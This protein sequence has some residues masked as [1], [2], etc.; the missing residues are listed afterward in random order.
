MTLVDARQHEVAFCSE[1]SK[2]SDAIFQG[3]PDLPFHSS[4]IEQYGQGSNK[5]QDFRVYARVGDQRGQLAL[6]GEVKLPGTPQGSSPFNAILLKDAHD[7]A[8]NIACRYYFTWNVERLALF[9]R[10][11]WNRPMHEQCIGQWDLGLVVNSHS[12]L[13]LPTVT[14]KIQE[15]LL[16][17]FYRDFAEIWSGRRDN[18]ATAPDEFYIS[19]LD[20]HLRGP[21]GPVRIM[22]DYLDLESSRNRTFDIQLRT[23][24]TRIQ[25]WN[26]DRDDPDSWRKAI[27]RAAASV[28]YVLN[29]RILFYEAVRARYGELR[30]LRFP[31][32]TKTAGEAVKFLSRQFQ[33]AIRVTGDYDTVLMPDQHEWAAE[34]ALSGTN[35]IQSWQQVIDGVERFNF[36]QIPSDILGRTFQRLVSPEERHKFGQHYTDET[37]VDVINAFC[38]R[39]GADDVLDPACG[40]GS[41]LVRAYYRKAYLDRSLASHE[42]VA[43]LYGCDINPFPAHLATLNLAARDL[44][45]G[46]YPR[47]A[48]RNFFTVEPGK[49]FCEVPKETRDKRGNREHWRV[50]LPELDAVVGNP[51][52]VRQEQ[53][54]KKDEP[55]VI[56][57]QGKEF[58]AARAQRAFPGIGLS[59]QSDLHVYFW[60]VAADLLK[61]GGWF[62]FLTSS[63]W[64]DVRYGFRLQRWILTNFRLVAIIESLDEPWFQDA[65]V[66]TAVTILQRTADPKKR[67]GNLVRFV[68]LLRPLSV[69]LGAR[70]DEE[71]KQRG[72]ERLRNLIV[73]TKTDYADS[74]LRIVV[75]RQRDLWEE[76]VAVGPV[77]ARSGPAGRSSEAEDSDNEPAGTQQTNGLADYAGGKWGRYLRAPEFYFRV[78]RRFGPRFTRFGEVADIRRG[79]TSGCDAFFMPRDVTAATLC[80][81]PNDLKWRTLPAVTFGKRSDVAAGKVAVVR[82]GDGTLHCVER[83]YLKLEAHSLMDVG[84]PVVRA[85]DLDR[86]VLWVNQSMK[87]LEGQLIHKFLRWGA[88][89]T[90]ASARSKAIPLPQRSTC[91]GREMWYDLTGLTPGA[92]FWPM[93]Q[94]YRH[95][96]PANPDGVPCNHNLFDIHPVLEEAA[97]RRA[98]MPVLNCTLVALFK[99]FYGRYAGTEGNLKTEVVDTVV[100]EIPDPRGAAPAVL[101]RLERAFASMQERPVTHLV[102][103]R[104]MDCHTA[105]EVRV[106]AEQPPELPKELRQPDRRELDDAV[107]ELLGVSDAEERRRLTDELYW[108]VAQHFRSI[109]IVEVR[110]ME[111]RRRGTSRETVSAEDLSD[112]A[113]LDVPAGYREPLPEWLNGQTREDR[114]VT[115]PEGRP[116]LPEPENMFEATTIY[117]GSKPA[118]AHVCDTRPEAELLFAIA[119]TGFHGPVRVPYSEIDCQALLSRLRER[120]AAG[121]RLIEEAASSRAGSDRLREQ[122]ARILM[123]RF[124]HGRSE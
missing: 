100:M 95:I 122:L 106:A 108:E 51:P 10:S 31:K 97:S 58:I 115:I 80:E 26:F 8:Q 16:P 25:Q 113:W 105:D 71:Q 67:D 11:L 63:S 121:R 12:E 7:K 99:T 18:F 77:L 76:G 98:L 109:R 86:F 30:E 120:L 43:G 28:A 33:Q 90:F 14:A 107:W 74:N 123:D 101:E 82:C 52:Y 62:G 55:G 117:F 50:P 38:I 88:K 68:R 39:Q 48:R 66:K 4:A 22:R 103:E 37:I 21:M 20:S 104:L 96:I 36:H 61:E 124:I 56:A 102:E 27:E 84:R 32:T 42:I 93:A 70:D 116:R 34:V 59:G 24:M 118:V 114:L 73:R 83:Q 15:D 54:P 119:E 110:K 41:F 81:Y 65:R 89:Q 2:W 69:I 44:E 94:Q 92:G 111:Q 87:Q 3:T 35:A 60:P 79:I 47:I 112:S 53:I 72:A 13:S 29:N 46:N 91:V 19:V 57:D 1:V 45:Q 6:S 75:K 64:L 17:R 5:R 49:T 85:A 23:W 40:S 78:M 9:D